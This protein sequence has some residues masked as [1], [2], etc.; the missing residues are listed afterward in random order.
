MELKKTL[1]ITSVV[2]IGITTLVIAF[3][4]DGDM[5]QAAHCFHNSHHY[6]TVPIPQNG[7]GSSACPEPNIILDSN[8]LHIEGT[9]AIKHTSEDCYI[10]YV[11]VEN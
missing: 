1:V 6:E 10:Y 2:L 3:E 7:D 4:D 5:G 11:P 9:P 8:G